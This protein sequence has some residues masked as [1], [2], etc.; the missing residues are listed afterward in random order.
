ML[1]ISFLN[2]LLKEIS[3]FLYQREKPSRQVYACIYK[4]CSLIRFLYHALQPVSP[5]HRCLLV[6]LLLL[7]D[8]VSRTYQR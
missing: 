4:E 8:R 7:L 3:Y 1:I 2:T 5:L 6:W